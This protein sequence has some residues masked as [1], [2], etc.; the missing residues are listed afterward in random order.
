MANAQFKIDLLEQN[1]KLVAEISELKKKYTEVEA[2]NVK[3]RLVMEEN[4]DLKTRLEVLEKKNKT[5]TTILIAE[6]VE[7]KDR[8]TKLEQNQIQIITLTNRKHL[9]Q[10]ILCHPQL[11]Q[12]Y[13]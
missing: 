3:L 2:K 6:N 13:L 10:K 1:S 11:V 8:V 12:N 5:D 7:L 4:T 9:P